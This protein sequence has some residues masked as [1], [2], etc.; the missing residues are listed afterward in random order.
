MSEALLSFVIPV[1]PTTRPTLSW[2]TD[3]F[4]PF[5]LGKDVTMPPALRREPLTEE[6]HAALL[7]QQVEVCNP[8]L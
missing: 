7:T 6:E 3:R 2:H 5:E 4:K 8:R 1:K